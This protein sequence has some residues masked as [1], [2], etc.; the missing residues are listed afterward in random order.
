MNRTQRAKAAME[1]LEIFKKGHYTINGEKIDCQS[2]YTTEF[3]TEQQIKDLNP[4]PG[5][6]SP[7][8]EVANESVVAA[9]LR[10]SPCGVLNFASAKNPGGG[11]LGGSLA[12]EEALAVSSDMYNSQL[13]A[14][15]LYSI[16]KSCRSLLYTHN[17]IYSQNITFIRDASMALIP[18]PITTNILTAPAVNAG[19]YYKNEKGS[20]STVLSV[21]EARMRYILNVFAAKRDSTIILGAY[22]CGVFQND[23]SDVAGIFYHL[24]KNEEMEKHFGHIIFA[25]YDSKGPQYNIF[26][27]RFGM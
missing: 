26:N 7:K 10:T 2:Q 3:L 9:I 6:Q 16:N 1:T 20:K 21:M 25:V 24:L 12:Q 4:K 22:G 11:F 17:M 15:Q 18:S 8:Y 13:Q 19:A 14:S 23:T 27:K 5:S